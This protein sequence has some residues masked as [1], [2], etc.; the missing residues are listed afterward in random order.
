MRVENKNYNDRVSAIKWIKFEKGLIIT[1]K[2]ICVDNIA[3][4]PF[5]KMAVAIL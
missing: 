4:N 1:L 5:N 3:Q 2:S